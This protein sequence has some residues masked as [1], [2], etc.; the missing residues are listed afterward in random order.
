[1]CSACCTLRRSIA[2]SKVRTSGE[3]T[4]SSSPRSGWRKS[5]IGAVGGIG[6]GVGPGVEVGPLVTVGVPAPTMLDGAVPVGAGVVPLGR[7]SE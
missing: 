2:W 1:M 4:C 3:S 5:S 7:S 6:V